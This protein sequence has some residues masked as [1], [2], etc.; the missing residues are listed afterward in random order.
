MHHNPAPRKATARIRELIIEC[1][2]TP[3]RRF[4][5][6][7]PSR[8][9]LDSWGITDIGLY[10][11]LAEDLE[12]HELFLKPK[13]NPQQP[14]KYQYVL[15]GSDDDQTTILIH[16]TMGHNEDPPMVKLSVHPHDTGYNPLPRIPINKIR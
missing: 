13:Q 6:E 15:R 16:V 12:T 9:Y 2:K 1:L 7:N 14:Q 3:N 8:H 5:H 10:E 4:I 11:E